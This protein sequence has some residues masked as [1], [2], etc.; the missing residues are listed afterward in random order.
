[1]NKEQLDK[2]MARIKSKLPF[3]PW[4]VQEFLKRELRTGSVKTTINYSHDYLIFFNWLISEGYFSGTVKDVPLSVLEN[5]RPL[6][7]DDFLLYLKTDRNN[8]LDA[9]NRKTSSLKSLFNYL[10]NFAEHKTTHE[11]YLTRNVMAKIKLPK[12]KITTGARVNKIKGNILYTEEEFMDFR[13]F[14]AN[15]YGDKIKDNKKALTPYLQFRERDIALI[16]LIL[17]SGIRLSEAAGLDIDEVDTQRRTITIYRKGNKEDAVHFSQIAQDD[18]N[19]YLRVRETRYNL[20]KD[21]KPLFIS[22]KRGPAG[23]GRMSDRA[24]QMMIEKYA[25]AYGKPGMTV[26]KLRHSFA[27]RYYSENPDLLGLQ[28]QLGHEDPKTTGIYAH[29]LDSRKKDNVKNM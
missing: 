4:Y 14:V 12:K 22:S 11:P 24:I 8:G 15:D 7:I 28:E 2:D 23:S 5:L 3:L 16:S 13:A 9:S 21:F 17:G 1:M 20:P 19:D 10:T 29:V 27:T 26:H 6:D 25:T 18:L